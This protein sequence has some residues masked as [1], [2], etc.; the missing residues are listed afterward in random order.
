MGKIINILPVDKQRRQ[1]AGN[2]G[3]AAGGKR[4][5][6]GSVDQYEEEG[7]EEKADTLTEALDALE[8]A[9]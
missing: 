5:A 6:C 9:V 7:A 1:S 3:G 4:C 8:D 2:H